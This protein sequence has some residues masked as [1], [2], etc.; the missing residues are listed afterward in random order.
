M[1]NGLSFTGLLLLAC[2]GTASFGQS[3]NFKGGF[4]TS[5]IK[6]S[7]FENKLTKY[8]ADG[9]TYTTIDKIEDAIGFHLALA[10]EF[11]L[12]TRLSLETGFR[13]QSRGFHHV[14]DYAFESNDG[15]E[16]WAENGD[17][18]AYYKYL[19]LPIVL[20]T[21]ITTG[22]FRVYARTGI[23]AGLMIGG[24]TTAIYDYPSSN[25][26][27]GPYEYNYKLTVSDMDFEDRITAGFIV[28]LGAEYKGF[29]FETNYRRGAFKVA[30]PDSDVY[31][32]DL[33]FSLG[34]KLKFNQ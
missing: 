32:R 5:I 18:S 16:Y 33:S 26:N 21:A 4:T 28:G 17:E 6:A 1:K 12:G 11:R 31:T 25:G 30:D 2:I 15:A 19:D 27:F 8:L 9:G 20:N 29:Y 7:D 3:L 10:Y 34:Y 14:S 13:Y 24:K 22:D 23:Y